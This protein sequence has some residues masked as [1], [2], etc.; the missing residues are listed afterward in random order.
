MKKMMLKAPKAQKMAM[1]PKSGKEAKTARPAKGRKMDTPMI[2]PP[3]K[4]PK[5]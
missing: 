3:K 2:P 4:G 1:T 5:Y